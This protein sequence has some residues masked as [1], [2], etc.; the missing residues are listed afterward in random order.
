MVGLGTVV[1]SLEVGDGNI[2][3]EQREELRVGLHLPW[4]TYIHVYKI[5]LP[6]FLVLMLPVHLEMRMSYYRD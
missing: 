1:I 3:T 2:E 4:C 6:V 5:F